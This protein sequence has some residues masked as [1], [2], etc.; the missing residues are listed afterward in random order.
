MRRDSLARGPEVLQ[1]FGIIPGS[2]AMAAMSSG[3]WDQP[4]EL[5]VACQ[6]SVMAERFAIQ[7]DAHLLQIMM[8]KWKRGQDWAVQLPT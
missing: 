1:I 3:S 5:T 4:S 7:A 2:D 6:R 8:V